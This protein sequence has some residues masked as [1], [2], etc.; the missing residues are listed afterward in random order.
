MRASSWAST[1]T[2][3][4]RSVNRSNMPIAPQRGGWGHPPGKNRGTPTVVIGVSTVPTGLTAYV[5]PAPFTRRPP[6][7]NIVGQPRA[8]NERSAWARE[9][10]APA[11]ARAY[12]RVETRCRCRGVRHGAGPGLDRLDQLLL[13][14]PRG[15]GTLDQRVSTGST[16]GALVGCLEGLAHVGRDTAAVGH[17]L[18]VGAGP[19]ADLAG[20][21]P[22]LGVALGAGRRTASGAAGR[23]DVARERVAQLRGVL[24]VEVDLVAPAVEAE[25]HGLGRLAAVEVVLEREVDF[26]RH[27]VACLSKCR[28]HR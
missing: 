20:A 19:V 27:V 16:S 4:A 8:R 10:R 22:D 15:L 17:L 13:T 3:R 25:G 1:T 23:G 18:A 5:F 21:R 2:R 11:P 28:T 14:R 12:E 9:R 7:A 26:L 6:T 24:V